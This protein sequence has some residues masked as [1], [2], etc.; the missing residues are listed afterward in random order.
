M[1]ERFQPAA[2]TQYHDQYFEC[3]AIKIL[4]GEYYASTRDMLV[5]TVLGSC[6]SVCLRD[7]ATGI[8]GM[9]HFMLPGCGDNSPTGGSARYG[10]YAME[11]LI[12]DLLKLG[13]A[14]SRLQAKVFGGGHVLEGFR[15]NYIGHANAEFVL[16]YLATERIPVTAQDL[17]DIYPRKVYFFIGSGRVLVR[18]LKV[19]HNTTILDREFE[20][21]RK[22]KKTWVQGD[23]ELFSQ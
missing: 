21:S 5:V 10:S 19:Q 17:L 12:N 1:A 15:E 20:Y 16:K 6:V 7:S 3:E 14:R 8:G 2:P 23:V 18:K 4:P 11:L 9:N 22:L 13:A